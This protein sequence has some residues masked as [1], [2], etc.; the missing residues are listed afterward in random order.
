[1]QQ[2]SVTSTTTPL[3]GRLSQKDIGD[4]VMKNIA[5]FDPCYT[6]GTKGGRSF[7]AVVTVRATLGPSGAVSVAETTKS[8]AKNAEV[9][10][11]V[12]QAFKKIKFPSPSDGGTAVITFPIEFSAVQQVP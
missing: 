7:T 5:L 3:G 10:T 4:I 2:A 8:T 6:I 11:C 1:M 9:D 12:A